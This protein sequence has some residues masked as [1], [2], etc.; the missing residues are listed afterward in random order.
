MFNSNPSSI[1]IGMMVPYTQHLF[2]T[3]L[4]KMNLK[5]PT[6]IQHFYDTISFLDENSKTFWP[7]CA[8]E[9][10]KPRNRDNCK[11]IIIISKDK[12]IVDVNNCFGGFA[13]I[14]PNIV[15]DKRIRWNTLSH[16]VID[17][18]SVCEHFFILP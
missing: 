16:E 13:F 6:F 1:N 15:N 8:F 5:E 3:N 9:N 10:C 4:R 18:E 11:D 7:H 14:K 12:N 2:L 17:D